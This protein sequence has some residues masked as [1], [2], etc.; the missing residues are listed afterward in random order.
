MMPLPFSLHHSLNFITGHL[1]RNESHILEVGCGEGGLAQALQDQGYR[2]S[3]LDQ[4]EDCVE[5]ARTKGVAACQASWPD[6]ESRLSEEFDAVLFVRSLHHVEDLQASVERAFSVL[7]PGGVLLVEDFAFTETPLTTMQWFKSR[8]AAL[9]ADHKINIPD[10]SFC[11]LL[12]NSIRPEQ[13]WYHDHLP[14]IH[15]LGRMYREILVQFDQCHLEHVP[16]L[17]RYIL[18]MVPPT[19]EGR[20]TLQHMYDGEMALQEKDDAFLVGRR[21]MAKKP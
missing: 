8:L 17:Y 13:V 2:L 12:L 15:P 1:P 16:Y 7:K 5:K 19:A 4:S 20:A 18:D 3:A 6:C 11:H 21:M 10:N 14:H 9:T